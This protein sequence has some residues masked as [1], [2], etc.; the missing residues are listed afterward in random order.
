MSY[1]NL[2]VKVSGMNI[3]IFGLTCCA[4]KVSGFNNLKE[5]FVYLG[6]AK[7]LD[8]PIHRQ[9]EPE[10]KKLKLKGCILGDSHKGNK[11]CQGKGK[12]G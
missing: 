8:V 11:N 5:W 2:F 1:C 7:K 10:K 9:W 4:Y 3:N 6:F 12:T